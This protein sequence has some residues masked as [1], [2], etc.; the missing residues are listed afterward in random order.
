VLRD[1]TILKQHHIGKVFL[2][3]AL[4]KLG[5]AS[6]SQGRQMILD[7]RVRVNGKTKKDPLFL[8]T[9]ETAR[10]E[11]DEKIVAKAE[12]IVLM[13]HK[14]RGVVTTRSDEKGRPTVFSLIKDKSIYLHT[15]GR[16]DL[17]TTGLLLL[18]NDTRFSDWLTDPKSQ[19]KR[20]YTVT[21]R[22][23]VTTDKAKCLEDGINDGGET[24]KANKVSIRK[25]SR[26]ETHLIVTLSQGKNREIRRLFKSIGHEVTQLKRVSFAGLEL[27]DLKPGDYRIV[28][29]DELPKTSP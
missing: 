9:P 7:G 26:K 23:E 13:L 27:G 18:T 4:S 2:E 3:R 29:E 19:F 25:V 14:P 6:R 15:V 28:K 16:L 22:G 20:V 24:L 12:R 17:A 5:L 1:L 11:I 8:V 21:V 10:I